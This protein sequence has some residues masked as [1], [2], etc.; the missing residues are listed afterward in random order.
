ME[1]P[2]IRGS[3]LSLG[4][5]IALTLGMGTLGSMATVAQIPTWYAQ[6]VKPSFNPPN[7]LFG[8]V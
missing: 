6:L 7:W 3:T 2:A 1:P 5:L 4:L 8:P